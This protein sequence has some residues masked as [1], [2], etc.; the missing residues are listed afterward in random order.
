[1]KLIDID[2]CRNQNRCQ[3]MTANHLILLRNLDK[4]LKL[5]LQ[6]GNSLICTCKADL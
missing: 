1:M 2:F 5:L 4:L 3:V 6:K